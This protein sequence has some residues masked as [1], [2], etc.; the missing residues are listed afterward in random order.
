MAN[1]ICPDN[2]SSTVAEVEFSVCAPK[3]NQSEIKRL[4]IAPA[5]APAFTDVAAASEWTTRLKEDTGTGDV[6]RP[7]TVIGDKPEAAGVEREISNRRRIRIGK[8]HTVNFTIDDVSDKNYEFMRATECG[9]GTYRIWYETHGGY[10]YGGNEGIK[11]SVSMGLVQNRGA[12]EIETI[13]GVAT[14][15]TKFHPERVVSPIFSE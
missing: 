14:W 10:L 4:F 3:V 6:I 7:L 12:D 13:N 5:D 15:R 1:P 9:S 11:A 2:C 8:D